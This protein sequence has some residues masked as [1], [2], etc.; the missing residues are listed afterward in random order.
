MANTGIGLFFY[1]PCYVHSVLPQPRADL[2]PTLRSVGK[3]LS[4]VVPPKNNYAHNH[5]QKNSRT[6]GFGLELTSY[7]KICRKKMF[8]QNNSNGKFTVCVVAVIWV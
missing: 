2:E 6:Y 8:M 3:R 4:M 1:G 7:W 5:C